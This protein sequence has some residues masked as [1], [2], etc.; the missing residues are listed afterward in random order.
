MLNNQLSVCAL[1][2]LRFE[3]QKRGEWDMPQLLIKA[4]VLGLLFLIDGQWLVAA[5]ERCTPTPPDMMGPFYKP[6]APLRSS[7]GKGYLI[8][9]TVRSSQDCAPIPG[10]QIEL[11]LTNPEGN[12]DDRH[13]ATVMADDAGTYRFE[14]S[15]PTDYG[16]RPPH[17]HLRI[18]AEG[19]N[20]LVTQHY[21]EEGRS[22]AEF[23][24]VLIPRDR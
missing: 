4:L 9:G 18:T 23:D 14:S 1:G 22:R 15:P 11:W 6:D 20:S 10:A 2:Y 24:L 8:T 16:F 17:I 5:D 21:P 3:V 13:R 12:Y 19:F 7:V